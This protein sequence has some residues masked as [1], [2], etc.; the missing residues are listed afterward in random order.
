[1]TTTSGKDAT[2]NVANKRNRSS[3]YYSCAIISTVLIISF[4]ITVA[5]HPNHIPDWY[6]LLL[7]PIILMG[8]WCFITWDADFSD[9]GKE[10]VV[11]NYK[12]ARREIHKFFLDNKDKIKNKSTSKEEKVRI[13][14]ELVESLKNLNS[15]HYFEN[16]VLLIGGSY[17]IY[18]LETFNNDIILLQKTSA[19]LLTII[20]L[21][22]SKA[23]D[24]ALNLLGQAFDT[25]NENRNKEDK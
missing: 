25:A 9:Q 2:I 1:M 15:K 18:P 4:I 5:T 11:I 7:L 21:A 6:I 3:L 10:Q 22:D 13:A 8:V 16:L 14:S 24:T 23:I 19:S 17:E 12:V 20:E